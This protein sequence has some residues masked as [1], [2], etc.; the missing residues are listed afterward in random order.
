MSQ[1]MP[2]IPFCICATH[3]LL[4]AWL[5]AGTSVAL[6]QDLYGRVAV[7]QHQRAQPLRGSAARRG[8]C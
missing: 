5:A 4:F 3:L 7:A 6:R 8:V 1:W 2:A